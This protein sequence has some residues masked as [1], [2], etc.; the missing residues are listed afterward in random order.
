[1]Q[2][3]SQGSAR[4]SSF[5][6]NE[7]YL[8]A[9]PR[10]TPD[11]VK[12]LNESILAL[13][14][15]YP[16]AVNKNMVILDGHSR[17]DLLCNLSKDIKYHVF[18]FKTE[19]EEYQFVVESNIMKRHLNNYQKIETMYDFYNNDRTKNP[20]NN[21]TITCDVIKS[22]KSGNIT[23]EQVSKHLQLDSKYTARILTS[24]VEDYCLSRDV[25]HKKTTH[26]STKY[27]TY[28]LMPKAESRLSR[29]D[30]RKT[31]I[32][33][34]RLIGVSRETLNRG[35][36]IIKNADDDIKV[37]LRSGVLSISH[38]YTILSA[39]GRMS[40]KGKKYFGACNIVE[41]PYCHKTIKK[42]E[43]ILK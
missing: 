24:L 13:G 8:S 22:I 36:H 5:S 27:Y 2:Q 34:S 40:T 7:K 29:N 23:C 1:M 30:V 12:S 38:V 9:I 18:D 39:S 14:Q 10:P 25:E 21:Y 16:I 15:L 11:E 17:F 32:G 37:K 3:L 33:I 35:L 43:L 42:K 20:I 28:K 26:G 6:I 4:N 41:C 19:E 31:I